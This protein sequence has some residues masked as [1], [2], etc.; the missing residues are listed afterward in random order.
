MQINVALKPFAAMTT[1]WRI[2]CTLVAVNSFVKINPHSIK[3]TR[4]GLQLIS[5]THSE[6]CKE[7]I[8]V[9]VYGFSDSKGSV[10]HDVLL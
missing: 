7:S 8:S 10:R 9:T 5:Q 6:A 3:S 1:A 2:F 4:C